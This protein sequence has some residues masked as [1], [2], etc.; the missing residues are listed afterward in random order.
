M[1]DIHRRVIKMLEAKLPG[2]KSELVRETRHVIVD[3]TYDGRK[4]RATM[5][6]SP[7][8]TDHAVWNTCKQIRVGLGV[9]KGKA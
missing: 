1:Q 8:D 9:V 2:I 4:F 3:F 5:A 6:K 7:R